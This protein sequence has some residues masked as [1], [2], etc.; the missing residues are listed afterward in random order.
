MILGCLM[1]QKNFFSKYF[2]RSR[3]IQDGA[4]PLL[5]SGNI[6]RMAFYWCASTIPVYDN[7]DLFL[8]FKGDEAEENGVEVQNNVTAH[9][10]GALVPGKPLDTWMETVNNY[11]SSSNSQ[12]QVIYLFDEAGYQYPIAIIIDGKFQSNPKASADEKQSW[13]T[14]PCHWIGG[15]EECV[16]EEKDEKPPVMETHIKVENAQEI[17]NFE[18]KEIEKSEKIIKTYKKKGGVKPTLKNLKKRK[19]YR[20]ADTRLSKKSGV[21]NVERKKLSRKIKVPEITRRK[22]R[23]KLPDPS[24]H[25]PKRSVILEV[26]G[27]IYFI[28][29]QNQAMVH[30][31]AGWGGGAIGLWCGTIPWLL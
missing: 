21:K 31:G 28:C 11:E 9:Y 30:K 14:E 1:V 23:G 18:G 10:D 20:P 8:P 17:P 24:Y 4:L 26:Q 25:A 22:R 19:I 2:W 16:T 6:T 5:W 7:N 3:A 13:Q 29:V 12:Q 27:K 15:Q